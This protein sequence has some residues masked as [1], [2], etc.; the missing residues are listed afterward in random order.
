DLA[1]LDAIAAEGI[2]LV[3][4]RGT[5]T[6]TVGTATAA[7]L[8]TGEG[9]AASTGSVP[10]TDPGRDTNADAITGR[11]ITTAPDLAL[12]FTK[13]M[14]TRAAAASIA[15]LARAGTI[16]LTLQ[17]GL[18]N[19]EA[20]AE[21]FPPERVLTGMAALPADLAGATEVRTHGSAHLAL[22]P[23]R[24]TPESVAA[25]ASAVAMLTAAGFEAEAATTA[26]IDVAIWEKVAF[27]AALNTIGAVTG[28][29]NGG[30]DNG[31][32]RRLAA[33][34][35]DEVA[36]TAVASGVA[37][38]AARI[39]AT[40][41]DALEQHRHHEASMLQDIRAHRRTE[42]DAIAGAVCAHADAHGMAVPV[43]RTLGDLVRLVETPVE[44]AG[45]HG[46][47]ES[48]GRPDAAVPD[49]A[50]QPNG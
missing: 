18:G 23:M 5:R 4:D 33:A 10:G 46:S 28:R 7:E 37:V 31:P 36:A 43:L 39:H 22:G 35:I 11:T 30:I 40:A 20:I 14:H 6:V 34:I 29:A 21:T 12:V 41:L 26:D 13:S 44:D 42:I 24:E 8:G 2:R 48:S 15:H 27:N 1:R 25:A 3:D 32:G 49:A 9:S 17:N 16:V 45:T 19:P 38:D 50:R 47:G